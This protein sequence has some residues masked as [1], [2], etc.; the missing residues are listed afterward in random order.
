MSKDLFEIH[1]TCM[2]SDK[3]LAL[4]IAESLHW[5][6]S[7]IARDPVLGN[8]I[9]FYLTKYADTLER[10]H[11]ML[12]HAMNMLDLMKIKVRR[13]KIEQIVHDIKYEL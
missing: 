2:T 8:D 5:K 13:E 1:I 6:T 11:Y 9:Y 10:A 3:E 12:S 7:E 4:E